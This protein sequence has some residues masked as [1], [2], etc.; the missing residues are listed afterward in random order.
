MGQY[1]SG[2]SSYAPADF[3]IYGSN[4]DLSYDIIDQKTNYSF[5]GTSG[6]WNPNISVGNR[7]YQ[8]IVFQVT[9]MFGYGDFTSV[10]NMEFG[11]A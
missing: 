1:N 3:T 7:Q 9:R 6:V 5:T 4:N 2:G 8:Y 11:Y 10:V